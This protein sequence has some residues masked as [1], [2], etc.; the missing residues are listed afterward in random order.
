MER[1]F[2]LSSVLLTILYSWKNEA[3]PVRD[4][5]QRQVDQAEGL[6]DVRWK[7]VS[8]LETAYIYTEKLVNNYISNNYYAPLMCIVASLYCHIIQSLQMHACDS[9]PLLT[10]GAELT[11]LLSAVC[12]LMEVE[13]LAAKVRNG[14][15]LHIILEQ[16]ILDACHWVNDN[17]G[18]RKG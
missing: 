12:E 16:N 1:R 18:C 3:V 5:H 17:I 14:S 15:D 10:A 2:F 7:L 11:T 9:E 4:I 13:E 6:D 8:G